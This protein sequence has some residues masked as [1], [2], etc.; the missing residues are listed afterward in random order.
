M[1]TALFSITPL[2]DSALIINYENIIS[3]AT[4]YLVLES[5]QKIKHANLK[6]ITDIVPAYSSIS[7]F[8]NDDAIANDY[9][10]YEDFY[11]DMSNK[12]YK[13][14]SSKILLNNTKNKTIRIPVCY[15]LKYGIDLMEISKLKNLSVQ[16]IINLHTKN[17]YL[18]YM[19]GFLPG[20]PYMGEVDEQIATPR[21]SNPRTNISAGS[22][23]IAGKQTG[24]YPLASP[25]GWQIIGRTPISL[26]IKHSQHPTLLSPGDE[27][28][29]Y[30]ITDD[31]FA[32]Y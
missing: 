19:I 1:N 14:L 17:K 25:G 31:E 24:I 16:S 6:G 4:N 28:E 9:K 32:N 20:F 27:V 22:V 15:S 5:Y 12:L 10:N 18:V 30:S 11:T 26:F 8:F 13:V 23:G 3:Q 29:F 2:G 7:V 21:K